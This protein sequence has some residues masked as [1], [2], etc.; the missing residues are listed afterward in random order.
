SK[1]GE[2]KCWYLNSSTLQRGTPLVGDSTW[3]QTVTAGHVELSEFTVIAAEYNGRYYYSPVGRLRETTGTSGVTV[4]G[5]TFIG[6]TLS[7][8]RQIPA[9]G[10]IDLNPDFYGDYSFEVDTTTYY[11]SLTVSV[12]FIDDAGRA[13]GLTV[14]T[15]VSKP[16]NSII[17][18]TWQTQ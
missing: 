2:M 15:T 16:G 9:G 8:Y 18:S 17:D 5:M 11:P 7:D 3:F 1:T 12:S 6:W 4:G 13:G 14:T 10:S